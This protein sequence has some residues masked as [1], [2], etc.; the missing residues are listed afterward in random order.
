MTAE[1]EVHV[2]L[3]T[4]GSKSKI[5]LNLCNGKE[6]PLHP[7]AHQYELD[8]P[9]FISARD[10]EFRAS[11]DA[12][13][14]S[15]GSVHFYPRRLIDSFLSVEAAEAT[16]R[17]VLAQFPQGAAVRTISPFGGQKQHA[18]H[19]NLGLA[20]L[21]LYHSGE[22]Q[23]LKLFVEPYCIESCRTD[24]PNLPLTP[25]PATQEEKE[26]IRH[27]IAAYSIWAPS[28]G[29]YAIGYH[30]VTNI[31]NEFMCNT[32]A[33]YHFPKDIPKSEV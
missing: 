9:Q 23:D 12:L 11:C 26:R 13:G 5:R 18:D 10:L 7:G 33:W 27:G 6:C 29:R 24:H 1:A 28:H 3:C 4:D 15:P 19:R 2:V 14:Y 30:S 32:V 20:A 21:N 31:F 25:L 17:S 16:I 22:I 8:I